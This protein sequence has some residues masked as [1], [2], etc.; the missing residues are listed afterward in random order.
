MKTPSEPTFE[1][2]QILVDKGRCWPALCLSLWFNENSDFYYQYVHGDTETFHLAFRKLKQPYHLIRHPVHGLDATMCQH[3]FEGRRLFQHR[4]M[5]K[6][7]LALH[8]RHVPDF[9][10]ENEC[11]RF[12]RD[13]RRRWVDGH[14]KLTPKTG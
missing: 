8:N 4:N 3:D 9:W 1:T 2:G 12:V 10:Y 11:R 7:N 5:D 14:R 6:W 13:L